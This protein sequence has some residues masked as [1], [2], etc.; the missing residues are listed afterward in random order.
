MTVDALQFGLFFFCSVWLFFQPISWTS[1]KYLWDQSKKYALSKVKTDRFKKS[2]IP[3]CLFNFQWIVLKLLCIFS[4]F[5]QLAVILFYLLIMFL[6]CTHSILWLQIKHLL[7]YYVSTMTVLTYSWRN[8]V[9]TLKG[10]H[11]KNGI[12]C[13]LVNNNVLYTKM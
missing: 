4:C 12:L 8:D 3:H 10:T 11:L 5:D 1:D 7:T 13:P 6:V 2:F 9:L